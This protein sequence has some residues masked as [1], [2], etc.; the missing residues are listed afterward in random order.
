MNKQVIAG[1]AVAPGDVSRGVLGKVMPE[2]PVIG[3]HWCHSIIEGMPEMTWDNFQ[4]IMMDKYGL[5]VLYRSMQDDPTLPDECDLEIELWAPQNPFVSDD[6]FLL[7]L[8]ED[9]D[10]P[11][12]VWG[13]PQ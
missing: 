9:E 1:V 13:L 7:S 11:F 2:T 4:G 12:A 8:G 10:G 6:A 5:T 3:D